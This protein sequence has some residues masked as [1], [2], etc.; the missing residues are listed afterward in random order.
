MK[1][2][3]GR[4]AEQDAAIYLYCITRGPVFPSKKIRGI[5]SGS[6]VEPL[7]CG[8][9][10]C[11][12]SLVPRVEF[13]ERLAAN[14][15]NLDWVAAA[16][17][18]HQ[19]AVAEIARGRDALPARFGVV[20]LSEESLHADIRERAA[21][22]EADFQRVGNCDE[23]GVK[24][25]AAPEK[26]AAPVRKTGAGRMTG[27]EYLRAKSAL[28]PR[29]G[30][31]KRDEEIDPFAAALEQISRET[32]EAGRI[33][34][35]QRGILYQTS[36]LIERRK[37]GK[38]EAILKRFSKEWAGSLRIECTGPWPAYSFVSRSSIS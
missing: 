11:W 19:G 4:R 12:T 14:M 17:M 2:G 22:L 9:L 25:F 38:L 5:D 35:G 30:A 20:F 27:K 7:R 29:R 18:R 23:W 16:S 6:P 37:R 32:A 21:L 3:G 33:S 8:N 15:E 26:A 13:T 24:V 31:G 10:V 36:L 1:T 28:L 34:G